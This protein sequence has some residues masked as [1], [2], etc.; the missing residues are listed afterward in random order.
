MQSAHF[1]KDLLRQS[2]ETIPVNLQDAE[3]MCMQALES[4]RFINDS[5]LEADAL[6][7]LSQIVFTQGKHIPAIENITRAISIREEYSDKGKLAASYNSYGIFLDS[8]G[9]RS[10]ALEVYF[11]SLKLK[12][13]LGDKRSI[14]NTLINI[15]SIYNRMGNTERELK[16]Y[17]QALSLSEELNDEKTRA[18]CKLNLGHLYSRMGDYSSA[19]NSLD[20][21]EE[22]LLKN[23]DNLNAGKA[24]LYRGEI[25]SAMG[26]YLKASASYNSYLEKSSKTGNLHGVVVAMINLAEINLKR[27]LIAEAKQLLDKSLHIAEEESL[28]EYIR[29]AR[30]VL[31]SFY[32]KQGDYQNALESYRKFVEIKDELNN[33]HNVK[34]LEEMHLKYDLEKIAR[35]AEIHQLKN[36]EL[37]EALDRLGIEKDRSDNLLRNILPDEV[38]DEL[39]IYGSAKAKYYESVTVMFIDIKNFTTL[40]E[41]LTPEAIVDEI[42][43]LFRNFDEIINRHD[44]EK[45]KTIGDAY[46]CAGGIP[47]PDAN[48]AKKIAEA[49]IDITKFMDQ[50]KRQRSN[51]G[52]HYFEVRIG[53]SSGPVVAGIVGSL[54]FAYD[55]WGDTV[56]TAARMEQC[57][58]VSAI[59]I[60]NATYELLR[61]FYHC[62]YR[63]KIEAKNKGHID[64]Y[65]LETKLNP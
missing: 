10:A 13:E 35:E 4:S 54:K 1:I 9:D 27:G 49:A 57:G 34:L 12:E 50:L 58:E 11:K 24:I 38:A 62:S 61:S 16:I 42:D 29:D 8:L 65:F 51:E 17:Q 18:Y 59:N 39:K 47:V 46:M 40:S 37:K 20:G 63:G 53:I 43:F 22:I 48:H 56:N 19:L 25:Y 41:N 55:I 36:V 60:S 52:R 15:G 23:G 44:V 28:K 5:V 64:M 30:L 3:I 2:R 31:T 45:I 26:D 6:H 7:L 21:V 33:V 14:A 32:E